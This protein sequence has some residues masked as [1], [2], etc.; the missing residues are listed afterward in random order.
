[1][2]TFTLTDLKNEVS[3]KYAPT[4]IENGKDEYVLQNLLQLPAEKR[5][6]VLEIVDSLDEED[7]EKVGLD[8][9]VEKF[10]ELIIAAEE[11][12]KGEELLTLIGDNTAL[13][14]EL[15]TRWMET[16]QMGEAERS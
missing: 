7:G 14:I 9:Q 12:D 10:R 1:M 2:A 15:A 11:N 6:K 13:L 5:N 3:K 16:T 4:V 8:G